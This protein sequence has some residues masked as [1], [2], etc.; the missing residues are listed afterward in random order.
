MRFKLGDH[1]F[2]AVARG[3]DTTSKL[4]KIVSITAIGPFVGGQPS[5]IKGRHFIP[6]LSGDYIVSFTLG[7]VDRYE[8]VVFDWQLR[9]RFH[10]DEPERMNSVAAHEAHLLKQV[11]LLVAEKKAKQAARAA[12]YQ[13]HAQTFLPRQP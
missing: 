11:Q 2:L 8:V 4:G 12:A 3:Q 5:T 1:A 10:P 6:P 9:E 7:A 13:P